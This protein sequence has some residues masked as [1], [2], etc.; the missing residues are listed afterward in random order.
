VYV[1]PVYSSTI[2]SELASGRKKAN[3]ARMRWEL[4]VQNDI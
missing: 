4:P 3:G 2:L 1:V